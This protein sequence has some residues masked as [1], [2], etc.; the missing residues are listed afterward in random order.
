MP[1]PR[2][3]R[4]NDLLDEHAVLVYQRPD[5]T[6]GLWTPERAMQTQQR[7][8]SPPR[9]FRMCRRCYLIEQNRA[10]DQGH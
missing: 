10:L 5:G 7:G 4:C 3:H 2:C 8:V 1:L 6:Y 9:L